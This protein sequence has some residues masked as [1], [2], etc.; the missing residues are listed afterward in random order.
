MWVPVETDLPN[1][2]KSLRLA[3]LLKEPRAW[4]RVVQLWLWAIQFAPSGDLS[5]F[6]EHELA[7][8]MGYTGTSAGRITRDQHV[9]TSLKKSGFVDEDGKLHGW[10][11]ISHHLRKARHDRLKKRRQ[12]H[13]S[14]PGTSR[15]RPKDV[16]A[17]LD[18][19]LTGQRQDRTGPSPLPPDDPLPLPDSPPQPPGP[20]PD[21]IASLGLLNELTCRTYDPDPSALAQLHE[22][23]GRY[24]LD[25]VLAVIRDRVQ[26][27]GADAKMHRFLRPRTLFERGKFD[28]Y[29]NGLRGPVT[30]RHEPTEADVKAEN[31]FSRIREGA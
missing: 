1:H 3:V 10:W 7:V 8:A 24:G 11:R 14:V 31:V 21:C 16:E 12:R 13:A 23:H 25:Q 5:E 30:E 18:L 29:V 2:P 26:E 6:T 4:T 27:W 22:I 17:D 20:C 19:D 9:V 15:G 28:D